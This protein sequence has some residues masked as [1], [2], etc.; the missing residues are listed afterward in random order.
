MS[1]YDFT[2]QFECENSI[3]NIK[4]RFSDSMRMSKYDF[5]CQNT[6]IRLSEN[7]KIG[8]RFNDSVRM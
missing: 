3:L 8:F 4:I 7:V 2:T 5:E 6:I 1:K